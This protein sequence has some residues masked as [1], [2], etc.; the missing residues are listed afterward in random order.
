[1]FCV[2][3]AGSTALRLAG[4]HD[5]VA[6]DINPAELAYTTRRAAGSSVKQGDAERAS[7]SLFP[8]YLKK[9]GCPG[10]DLDILSAF[11]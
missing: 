11:E 7:A 9:T 4:Q 3:S 8:R 2:A 6:C 10:N 1:M 5:V